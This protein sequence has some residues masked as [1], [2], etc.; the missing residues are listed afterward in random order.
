MIQYALKCDNEHSFDSWFQ[1]AAA[2]EKL[3]NAGMVT[4]AICGS[5]KV[6]KAI[7]APSV[8]KSEKGKKNTPSLTKP[9]NSAEHAIKKLK[10]YV[11]SN[12][13]YVGKDFATEARDM[14]EGTAPE[15]SIYGEAKPE[16]AKKLIEDGIPVTPLPFALTR[17]AN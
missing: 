7:M 5:K 4:C 15:R 11:E 13:D 3:S 12:S 1:S 8:K 14:H 10:T 6:D 9:T 17:K 2:F 16:D